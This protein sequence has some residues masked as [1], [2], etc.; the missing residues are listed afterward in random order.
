MYGR[1]WRK[2]EIYKQEERPG[3]RR[4]F[5]LLHINMPIWCRPGA[6]LCRTGRSLLQHLQKLVDGIVPQRVG[7]IGPSPPAM[8]WPSIMQSRR[9]AE[10]D[11]PPIWHTTKLQS[12]YRLPMEM[13]AMG[14][15]PPPRPKILLQ[16]QISNGYIKM[17]N[18][19]F[20][21][22]GVQHIVDVAY[23]KRA[24]TD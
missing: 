22:R 17:T 1:G 11:T 4:A 15:N 18:A 13:P 16:N 14:S 5:L 12:S 7:A 10:T 19:L 3:S 8:S 24:S 9:W 6:V 20:S 23:G 2:T 21:N